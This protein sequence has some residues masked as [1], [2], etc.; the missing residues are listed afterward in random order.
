MK[1]K[2]ILAI[3]AVVLLLGLYVSTILFAI[4]DSPNAAYLF[5]ASIFCTIIIPVLLY[6]YILICRVLGRKNQ[7][8]SP[9][10]EDKN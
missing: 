4:S 7:E 1:L 2:R 3:I 9:D 8:T 10:N 6:A 5:K